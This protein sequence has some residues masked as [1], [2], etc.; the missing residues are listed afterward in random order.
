MKYLLAIDLETTGLEP[1]FHE[2]TEIGALLIRPDGTKITEY[3]FHKK[4]ILK[5]PDRAWSVNEDG[6]VFDTLDY[7]HYFDTNMAGATAIDVALK[8]MHG[9]IAENC[10]R[11]IDSK[12]DIVVFGQ[13]VKF[14]ISFLQAAYRRFHIDWPFNYHS[15]DLASIWVAYYA[16]QKGEVPASL[17]QNRM[18]EHFGIKN[19]KEHSATG[20]IELSIKLYQKFLHHLSEGEL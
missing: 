19:E 8:D 9:W 7:N 15:I 3:P 10:G 20:D 13:N 11:G 4:I 18:A 6:S 12:K 1:Y 14:D 2:I 16:M 5:R 17:S